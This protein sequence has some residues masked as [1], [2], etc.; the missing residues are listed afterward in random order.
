MKGIAVYIIVIAVAL[1]SGACRHDSHITDEL[2]RADGLMYCAPDSALS[3][4]DSLDTSHASEE[5][6]AHHALLLT[7]A[8]YKNYL[9]E[10]DDSL[11][12]IAEK[13]YS[14]RTDS[15]EMQSLF[16]KGFVLKNKHD[17]RTALIMLMKAAELARNNRD[18]YFTGLCFRT[19]AEI[20]SYIIAYDPQLEAA[21]KAIDAFE[22]AGATE[23]ALWEHTT[24]A[25]ALIF[26][27]PER[28]LSHLSTVRNSE[29]FKVAPAIQ[30]EYYE[31]MTLALQASG[32]Y[33]ASADSIATACAKGLVTSPVAIAN[34]AMT[35]AN[36][37]KPW[38]ARKCLELIKGDKRTEQS[39]YISH[40]V[41]A[42][43]DAADGDYRSAFENLQYYTSNSDKYTDSLLIHPYTTA[44][45]DYLKDKADKEKRDAEELRI[46]FL[47]I[48]GILLLAI[49]LVA[50]C[51]A[52][53][54]KNYR[55]K[56]AEIDVL[57]ARFDLIDSENQRLKNE[58]RTKVDA[59][60][61]KKLQTELDDNISKRIEIIDRL[62]YLYL[63]SS[64]DR[65][66]SDKNIRQRIDSLIND[67]LMSVL[68]KLTINKYDNLP[69][70]IKSESTISLKP[71]QYNLLI[72]LLAGLSRESMMAIFGKERNTIAVAI[73]RLK[74]TISGWPEELSA[75]T[76]SAICK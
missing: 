17:L 21:L 1:C 16:L 33:R 69:G 22:K 10:T 3:I 65:I 68:E 29:Y 2:L 7:K 59:G 12:T 74:K 15:L 47:L 30:S 39:D 75:E 70:R 34:M 4:L 36:A 44:I 38:T 26:I 27:D 66:K 48:I 42:Y 14:G 73:H 20:Y 23:F 9:N 43:L 50:S 57:L 11:I 45:N 52:I 25:R 28:S 55:L 37:G 5:Q 13:Y 67:D 40:R 31:I 76:L 6:Q 32:D 54:R 8:R 41:E 63:T 51:L 46:K 58:I 53:T 71:D 19:Q 56:K 24:A 61:I 18:W 49:M 60:L 72:A 35:Y 62:C 64:S